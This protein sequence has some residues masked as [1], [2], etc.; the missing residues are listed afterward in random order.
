[1]EYVRCYLL[2]PHIVKVRLPS[3]L[4][5]TYLTPSLGNIT[6]APRQELATADLPAPPSNFISLPVRIL[7]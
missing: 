3:K 2:E 6:L 7:P 5:L 1:M 4:Y